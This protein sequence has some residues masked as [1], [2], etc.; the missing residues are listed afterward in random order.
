TA[1]PHGRVLTSCAGTDELPRRTGVFRFH[2]VQ[3]HGRGPGSWKDLAL[4]MSLDTET[5]N[6]P[7]VPPREL[8][9]Y[10]IEGEL[11]RGG[12]GVVYL[13]GDRRRDRKAAIR[14]LPAEVA[15]DPE[16]L[17]RFEREA[18]LLAS[19]NHPNIA[20]IHGLEETGDETR[21]LILERVEGETLADRVARGP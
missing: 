18:K 7:G 21:Y 5:T 16:Q 10:V 13:A 9:H 15:R 1:Y 6:A 14:T 3:S 19:L 20:T 4:S 2:R 11:G 12:M 17:A 8:G